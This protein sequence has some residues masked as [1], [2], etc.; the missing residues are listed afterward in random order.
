MIRSV[1]LLA[2]ALL[3]ALPLTAG[4]AGSGGRITAVRAMLFHN[5]T[6]QFSKDILPDPKAALNDALPFHSTLV[7]V[8]VSGPPN[9][10]SGSSVDF[11]VRRGK[12]KVAPDKISRQTELIPGFSDKGRYYASFWLYDTACDPVQITATLRGDE[13]NKWEKVIPFDCSEGT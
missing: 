12:G 1:L 4:A 7:V 8:E 9:G 13:A 3:L 5:Q 6:G 11:A 2:I 10:V